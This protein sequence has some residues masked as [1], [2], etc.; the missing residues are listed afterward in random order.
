[1]IGIKALAENAKPRVIP[2]GDTSTLIWG[3]TSNERV[4]RIADK[5]G[6]PFG[7]G[8][9]AQL[10]VSSAY[11]F[12][13]PLLKFLAETPDTVLMK[14]GKPVLAHVSGPAKADRVRDAMLSGE[15]FA[16]GDGLGTIVHN[17]GFT[18]YNDQLRKRDHPFL[19]RLLPENIRTI[20]RASYFGAYKGVTDLL[21]KYLWPEW[22]LVLTRAFARIGMTPNM[23]TGIGAAL[24]VFATWLFWNGNYW[25]GLAVG[26]VFMV[27]DTVDGKLARCTITSSR[28]GDI[29]DHGVDLIHPPFW[30][31]AWMAGLNQVG[32]PLSQTEFL[33]VM[34][35]ILIGYVV[36]RLVEGAFIKAFGIHIHVWRPFDSKFRLITARRNPN[37]LILFVSLL[38]FRPDLGILAVAWWTAISCVVHIV[39]LLQALAVRSRGGQVLSWLQEEPSRT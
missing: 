4:R 18:L 34:A 23:V 29:L 16:D 35:V 17:E 5:Q 27:L 30:Y 6:L 33:T 9:G 31:W 25:P 1:M 12:D 2:V 39:R 38:A 19:I 14:E 15:G 13:P 37:M 26:L 11:A 24:C 3:M 10:L 21:T 36:Q 7:E 28:I 32:L 8:E 20:E 22:A